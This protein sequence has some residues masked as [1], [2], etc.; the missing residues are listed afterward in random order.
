MSLGDARTFFGIS[1]CFCILEKMHLERTVPQTFPTHIII[2]R[3]KTL[4]HTLI[5]IYTAPRRN[6]THNTLT[7]MQT[8]YTIN[9]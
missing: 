3:S 1:D 4:K 9:K 2:R 6:Y 7:L 8:I 5:N